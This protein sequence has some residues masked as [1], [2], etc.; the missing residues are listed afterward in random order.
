MTDTALFTNW[1]ISLGLAAVVVVIAAVLIILIWQA[2]RRIL[3]LAIVAL[4]LVK[5]IK[6]NTATIWALEDTNKTA[7]AILNEAESIKNHGAAVAQALHN[8]SAEGG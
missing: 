6:Q 8:T 5:Q 1:Y 4:D 2:A 3:N 7:K